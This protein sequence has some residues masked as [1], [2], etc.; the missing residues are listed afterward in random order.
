MLLGKRSDLG[1]PETSSM[2]KLH[3]TRTAQ[4]NTMRTPKAL[5]QELWNGVLQGKPHPFL[6]SRV[7]PLLRAVAKASLFS[8]AAQV[9]CVE[10][11][12][13]DAIF[14]SGAWDV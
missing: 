6:C 10:L 4:K 1:K 3:Q 11:F 9:D 5:L 14:I 7:G 12:H 13:S 8:K 2:P